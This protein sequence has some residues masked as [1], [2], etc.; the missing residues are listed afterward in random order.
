[1][2]QQRSYLGTICVWI[3][4]AT[5]VVLQAAL[6]ACAPAKA[7]EAPAAIVLSEQAAS[8]MRAPDIEAVRADPQACADALRGVGLR[9]VVHPDRAIIAATGRRSVS[10]GRTGVEHATPLALAYSTLSGSSS[11]QLAQRFQGYLF[12]SHLTGSQREAAT[13]IGKQGGFVDDK[14]HVKEGGSELRVGIWCR[15]EPHL[16]VCG[17]GYGVCRRLNPVI[18]PPTSA[19]VE[20][21]PLPGSVLWWAWPH[22]AASWGNAAADFPPGKYRVRDV[23]TRLS[24]KAEVDI[25]AEEQAGEMQVYMAAQDVCVRDVLWALEVATGL[26]VR[27]V[28]GASPPIIAVGPRSESHEA[29]YRE[30]NLV[31]PI[32]GL[33][34]CSPEECAA[35]SYLLAQFEGGATHLGRHWVGWRFPELPLLYR[36]WILEEWQR[37]GSSDM[38][39]DL[40][41]LPAQEAYVLWLKC[42]VVSVGSF[43]A[44][45]AGGGV[46]YAIPAL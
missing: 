21:P 27:I 6:P 1:M 19:A 42:V 11:E 16:V 3:A 44:N 15:W 17:H 38:P 28:P 40:K 2:L 7:D 18:R 22:R 25:V 24:V 45:G 10:A 37:A 32:R 4:A 35:G 12:E 29:T 34:Y 41:Q 26:P 30:R 39:D 33:G 14:G 46:E 23:L 36:N 20:A 9:V 31:A 43:A 8:H 13:M 5:V